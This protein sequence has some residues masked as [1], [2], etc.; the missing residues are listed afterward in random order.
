MV[1]AT[2][3][4][5]E[6]QKLIRAHSRQSIA[7]IHKLVDGEKFIFLT[8]AFEARDPDPHKDY[9]IG[10][11]HMTFAERRGDMVID[12]S[13]FTDWHLPNVQKR[14]ANKSD[15]YYSLKPMCN[16]IYW[17]RPARTSE[18]QS[19][20]RDCALRGGNCFGY[21]GSALYGDKITERLLSEGGSGVWDEI[22]KAFEEA[23]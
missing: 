13:F 2:R 8:P 12:C 21:V 15:N 1:T 16:G 5:T 10:G 20:S 11:V 23:K 19:H 7:Q 14:L 6:S 22:D 4:L 18:Y 17:H 3:K 9:G